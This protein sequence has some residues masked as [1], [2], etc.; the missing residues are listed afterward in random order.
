MKI[1]PGPNRIHVQFHFPPEDGTVIL[2]ESSLSP[3]VESKRTI[4]E[5][6]SIGEAVTACKPG[7]FLLLHEDTLR[8]AVPISKEPPTA[9]IHDSVVLAIILDDGQYVR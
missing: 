1:K 5:C 9:L 3:S 2:P 8:N 4:V 6:L 7:D